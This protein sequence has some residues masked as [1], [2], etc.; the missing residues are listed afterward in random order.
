MRLTHPLFC[1]FVCLNA[2]ILNCY[3]FNNKKVGESGLK[4]EIF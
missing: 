2:C 3:N 4:W 1:I